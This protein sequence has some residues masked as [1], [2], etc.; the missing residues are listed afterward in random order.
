MN[1]GYNYRPAYSNRAEDP[2]KLW[3]ESEWR[4]Q[5]LRNIPT[6]TAQEPTHEQLLEWSKQCQHQI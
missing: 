2:R 5:F 1:E 6:K 3:L 4:L